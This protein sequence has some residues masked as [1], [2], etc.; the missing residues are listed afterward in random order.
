LRREA[1]KKKSQR[2]HLWICGQR[3][4]VDHNPTGA[5]SAKAK[6]KLAFNRYEPL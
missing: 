5:A 4:G 6:G 1:A 2:A 3:K